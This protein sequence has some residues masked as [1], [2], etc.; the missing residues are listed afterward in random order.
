MTELRVSRLERR[1]RKI[2]PDIDLERFEDKLDGAGDCFNGTLGSHVEG[3]CG[4]ESECFEEA[5][6][7]AIAL[8]NVPQFHRDT[9]L[10]WI[11]KTP[12]NRLRI[13]LLKMTGHL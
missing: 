7:V 8:L 11:Q 13:R 10:G 6:K 5:Y 3:L 4:H 1:L 9:L 2:D 12:W